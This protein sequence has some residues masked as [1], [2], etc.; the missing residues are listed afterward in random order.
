MHALGTGPCRPERCTEA[1]RYVAGLSSG[2][3]T[4]CE[5]VDV[6]V[7][8]RFE[9]NSEQTQRLLSF[10]RVTLS[11]DVTVTTLLDAPRV[12]LT[13]RTAHSFVPGN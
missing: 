8:P 9:L 11:L 1:R 13:R 6:L 5:R 4:A 7:S 2:C 10:K 12:F 3:S